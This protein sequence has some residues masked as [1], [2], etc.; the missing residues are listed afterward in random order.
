MACNYKCGKPCPRFV[1]TTAVAF[2]GDTLT[3]TLPEDIT[4]TAGCRYCLVIAQ[5]I[6]DATTIGADVVAVIGA[7]TTEFPLITRCGDPVTATQIGTRRKYP[8]LIS[9][10]A[11]GGT[12]RVLCDLRMWITQRLMH[13]TTQWKEAR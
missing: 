7:G 11:T 10:T 3:L 9:T 8:V 6:P 2:A 1:R 4:Y 5:T 12:I 13:S